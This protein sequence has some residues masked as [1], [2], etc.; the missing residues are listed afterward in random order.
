MKLD[1]N[2]KQG[3]RIVL[4]RRNLEALL[5]ALDEELSNPELSR[6]IELSNG[7]VFT[8]IVAAQEDS[9]H[10]TPGHYGLRDGEL[11]V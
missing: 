5:G 11:H 3:T 10:Y 8:V 1:W 9:A 4:S 7:D 6:R 2:I